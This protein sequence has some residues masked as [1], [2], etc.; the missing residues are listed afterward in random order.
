[1]K[2]RWVVAPVIIG[3]MAIGL[4]GGVVM[5]QT[6]EDDGTGSPLSSFVSRVASILGVDEAR[7]QEAFDQAATE[8]RDEAMQRK[9][10]A[11]VESGRLTQE[12]ADEYL[13]WYQSRP[14][15]TFQRG[16]PG[17]KFGG[18]HRGFGRRGW[19]HGRFGKLQPPAS[20][21]QTPTGSEA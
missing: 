11:L 16:I 4:T 7:V 1:M 6:G 5:A 17:P 9:L 2:R 10:A 20:A 13:E 18:G 21:P 15:D 3:L 8:L 12:Q 19:G 14:A